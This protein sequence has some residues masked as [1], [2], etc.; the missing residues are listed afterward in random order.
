MRV[1]LLGGTQDARALAQLLHDDPHFEGIS[2]L[3]G[4]TREPTPYPGQVRRGGFGGSPG[5]R[6]YLGEAGVQ[7]VVDATHPYAT[8][9]SQTAA[10]IV[11]EL[12]LPLLRLERDA[13]EAGAAD[14]WVL[15]ESLE[16]A[17]EALPDTARALL[18]TGASTLSRPLPEAPQLI[19]RM[20]EPPEGYVP[21]NVEV[22]L[23][24]PPFPEA[25]EREV[26]RDQRV[27]HL[28]TKNA[29][30]AR[31]KLD[32]A[33]ACEVTVL[34]IRRPRPPDPCPPRVTTVAEA[35]VWLADVA[36]RAQSAAARA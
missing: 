35:M 23:A 25:S 27:T 31:A 36:K 19:V 12:G 20:I 5:L 21:P 4:V 8:T 3:A 30:G 6:R 2:S 29:G 17:L 24:R 13:W 33:A 18:T 11:A 26:M 14:Q 7:V 1:L 9:M 15:C 28:I 16:R 32:A 10:T 22:L 34:M